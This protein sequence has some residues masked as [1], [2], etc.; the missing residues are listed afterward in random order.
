MADSQRAKRRTCPADERR[1]PTQRHQVPKHLSR[2]TPFRILEHRKKSKEV[3]ED[4]SGPGDAPA[5]GAAEESG[6]ATFASEGNED[7]RGEEEGGVAGGD[8][9]LE[10]RFSE[11][12]LR[13][14]GAHDDDYGL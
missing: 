1:H 2:P 4:E 3:A 9:G 10:S 14:K 13:Q 6:S 8:D 5:V 12:Q 11:A 7:A